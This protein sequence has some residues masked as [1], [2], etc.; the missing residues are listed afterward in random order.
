MAE[1]AV[2]N[3]PP[4]FLTIGHITRD[5]HDDGSTSLGGTVT[6]AAV[7]A[8]RSGFASAIVTRAS[9]Q[10][11]VDL[12]ELLSGIAVAAIPS[13][14]TTTFVNRYH[15]GIRTQYLRARA[16]SLQPDDIPA[17]WREAPIVL[18]GPLAQELSPD[19][20]QY[21]P[22]R[23]GALIAATPQG[24]LRRWDDAGR[25]W[26]TPW[27]DA[28]TI[29]PHLDVLILSYDDLQ[30]FANSDRAANAILAR[31]S[32]LVPLLI[33]TDGRN[34]A[35]LF[36]RGQHEHFSAYAATEVD[37][38]GAGDVFAAAFLCRLHECDDPR[39]AVNFANCVAS[40]SVEQVGIAG[41]PSR[42]IVERRLAGAY[43]I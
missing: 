18:L 26:P 10:L 37:P 8:A 24:W 9:E 27:T 28:K 2:G 29:L 25:V 39:A 3:G 43:F 40:F 23:N 5:L 38:T 6:F 12:P 15:D 14:C 35:T 31:W 4:T 20:A 41:I 19:F 42:Q 36:R 11:I 32:M 22:R 34:G 16:E 13:P 7:T 30:P 17:A 1:R 33:A 21:V